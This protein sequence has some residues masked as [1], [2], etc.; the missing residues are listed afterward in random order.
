MDKPEHSVPPQVPDS[1]FGYETAATRAYHA[2]RQRIVRC[3]LEP[4][5]IIN[6]RQLMDALQLGRTPIREALLRLSVERLVIFSGQGI[7]VAPVSLKH[8]SDLY[9]TRLHAERL[10]WQLWLQ[11]ATKAQI[12]QLAATFDTA[13][14]LLARNDEEGLIDLDFRFH[15]QVYEQCGNEVMTAHLYNLTGLSFRIWFLS[16]EHDMNV[17]AQTTRSHDPIISA[18]QARDAARLDREV[19]EHISH[20]YEAM[21]ERLKGNH[22]SVAANLSMK[23]LDPVA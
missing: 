2:I 6:D 8:I 17:H 14:S 21:V 11:S 13:P 12:A 16:N 18:V 9:A 7:Q 1:G 23:L 10:A 20:A 4:G 19:T 5:A 15:T 3:H 22:V